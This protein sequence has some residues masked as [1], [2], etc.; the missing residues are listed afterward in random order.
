MQEA[1]N[2][3]LNDVIPDNNYNG[4][5]GLWKPK[6]IEA[7]DHI[8]TISYKRVDV[9]A[10]FEYINKNTAS[11]ITKNA[12]E[13]FILQLTNQKGIINKKAP[14]GCDSFSLS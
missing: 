4:C 7:I 1:E 10:I 14:V 9:N 5:F 8:K 11:N 13:N 12:I 3:E 6:I 2:K